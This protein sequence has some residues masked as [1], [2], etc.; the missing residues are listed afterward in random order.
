MTK[1]EAKIPEE[2][3]NLSFEA[4]LKELEEIVVRLESGEISLED[5]IETY[6]RG[7]QLK[8]HCEEKLK[9][10][11]AKIEQITLDDKSGVKAAAPFDSE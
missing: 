6:T 1:I 9:T 2:I 3:Q 7:T 8:R 11:Q 4:A 5:S 10:A